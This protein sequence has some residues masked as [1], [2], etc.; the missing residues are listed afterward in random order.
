MDEVRTLAK[1]GEQVG[2]ALGT[3]IQVVR[4]GTEKKLARA[5]KKL[6]KRGLTPHQLGESALD[7]AEEFRQEIGKRGRKARKELA[8]A[9]KQAKKDLGRRGR[10]ARKQLADRL[11]PAP[12]RRRKWP[13]LL[14]LLGAAGGAAAWVL[15]K[16]PQQ[17]KPVV[18][19]EEA[20]RT[21][22]PAGSPSD[23]GHRPET[24]R[25]K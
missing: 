16:R 10:K 6:A 9:T 18:E 23:N 7:T 3:G 13:F 4:K 12:K 20:E 21:E 22:R 24:A 1:A 5:E 2:R 25:T 8:K 14:V 17:V 19:E 15:S 11:D